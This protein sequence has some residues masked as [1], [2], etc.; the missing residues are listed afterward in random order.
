L[1]KNMNDNPH[2]SL[3]SS[4]TIR[5]L[6]ELES[7]IHAFE[8]AWKLGPAP[9]ISQFLPPPSSNSSTE[10]FRIELLNELIRIDIEFKWKAAQQNF[11]FSTEPLAGSRCFVE[12][13]WSE[14][15]DEGIRPV[16]PLDLI[17]EEYRVRQLWGDRPKHDEYTS[18][19]PDHLSEMTALLKH[20]DGELQIEQAADD[21]LRS[22]SMFNIQSFPASDIDLDPLAPLS[23]GDFL[24]QKHLGTGGMGKVYRA[25]QKS[26]GKV[27]AVK[28]L[29]KAFIHHDESIKRFLEE[30]RIVAQLQHPGIVGVH[31]LGRTPAGGFF[32]VM[33]LI[34]GRDL[35]DVIQDGPIEVTQTVQWVSE[36]SNAIDY[37]HQNNIIH[38]DL[39]PS[40]VLCDHENHAIVTDFGLAQS[41]QSE[42]LAFFGPAGTAGYMAPEQIDSYW[43]MMGPHTDVYGLGAVL[44]AL[45]VGRAPYFGVRI[46]DV[47]TEVVSGK[48]PPAP[49]NI[50]Q[51]IPEVISS[52]CMKCLSANPDQRFSSAKELSDTLTAEL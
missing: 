31:G 34:Q 6:G 5:E 4:V 42:P 24:L 32:I 10:Q 30:A 14:F 15:K 37:A 11:A 39:K 27:V 1:L 52:I 33:D 50:N 20:I 28:Y 43:G 35:E 25:L 18:R 19:F 48:Q 44:Y 8:E 17:G 16:I 7:V 22:G 13:Y 3:N 9:S 41:L 51:K 26:L 36:I 21:E 40:N 38:C 49:H 12:D 2:F 29:K 46:A 23:F 47:L 45:L